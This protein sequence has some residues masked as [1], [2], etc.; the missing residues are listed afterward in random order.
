MAYGDPQYRTGYLKGIKGVVIEVLASDGKAVTPTPTRYG[1]RTPQE[2]NYEFEVVE[3]AENQ[4]RGGDIILCNVKENDVIVSANISIKNAKFDLEATT[5]INGGTLVVEEILTVDYLTGYEFP[6]I[7]EQSSKTPFKLEFYIQN[8]NS[9]G[10]QDSYMQV[11]F[12]YNKGYLNG[13]SHT[14]EEW[15]TPELSIKAEE[16]GEQSKPIMTI[17]WVDSL[18]T[19]LTA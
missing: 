6:T 5:H 1:I 9:S 7:E 16:N 3:G 17:D 18:P 13:L 10:Q 8:F 2:A 4:L 12:W 19:E 14:D 11:N 15:G